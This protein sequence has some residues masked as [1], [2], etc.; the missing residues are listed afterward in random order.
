[1]LWGEAGAGESPS[2]H[3]GTPPPPRACSAP[4]PRPVVMV[5]FVFSSASPGQHCWGGAVTVGPRSG[6]GRGSDHID[7]I[8]ATPLPQPGTLWA[9]ALAPHKQAFGRLTPEIWIVSPIPPGGALLLVP[10]L[11]RGGLALPPPKCLQSPPH[12]GHRTPTLP[13]QGWRVLAQSQALGWGTVGSLGG[14]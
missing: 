1:M 4:P 14:S 13:Q 12:H 5:T 9:V 8:L 10:L 11:W 3:R 2:G 7:W 6:A